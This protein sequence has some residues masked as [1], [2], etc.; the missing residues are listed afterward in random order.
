MPTVLFKCCENIS[1]KCCP[2]INI[3]YCL[4]LGD[5]RRARTQSVTWSFSV[6]FLTNLD[7]VRSW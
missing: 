2:P 5:C 6:I 7:N 3:G 4:Y 1:V